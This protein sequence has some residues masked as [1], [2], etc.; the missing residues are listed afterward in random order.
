MFPGVKIGRYTVAAELQGF[1]RVRAGD[2]RIKVQD[3]VGVD[4]TLGVGGL[5]RRSS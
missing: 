2:V 4:F 1:K 5:P 3:R